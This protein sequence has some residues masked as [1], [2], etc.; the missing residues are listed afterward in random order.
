MRTRPLDG[1]ED[2][3]AVRRL[4]HGTVALGRPVPFDVGDGY[5]SLC[6]DWFLGPGRA[7]AAVLDAD[8]S[9]SGGQVL[10]YV[11]V[12]TDAA[13]YRRWAVPRAL[14]WAAA[15][16]A[17]VATGLDRGDAA[18][19]TR[20]RLADGWASWRSSLPPPQPVLMHFNVAPG[21]RTA[22]AGLRLAA[23]VDQLCL[24]RGLPGWYGEINGPAGRRVAALERLGGEFVHRMPNRTLTWLAGRPVDRNTMMRRVDVD[25]RPLLGRSVRTAVTAR[26][27]A[28]NSASGRPSSR[29]AR[30][31]PSSDVAAPPAPT[32]SPSRQWV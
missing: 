21:A 11:L 31:A 24:D 27:A 20:L 25:Y 14:A 1:V 22:D 28:N 9:G 13:A 4:F 19:F 32:R 15:A 10:G 6:L 7:D 8:T 2:D 30:S 17:R 5:E 18:T 16:A 26:N 23:H 29:S 12:C 3:A